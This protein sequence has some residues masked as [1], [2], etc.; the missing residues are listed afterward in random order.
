MQKNKMLESTC[1][2]FAKK[3]FCVNCECRNCENTVENKHGVAAAQKL[4][5]KKPTAF[6]SKITGEEHKKGCGCKNSCCENRYCECN[7]YNV[8]CT[9]KCR[10]VS[11]K[12]PFGTRDYGEIT[13]PGEMN[14]QAEQDNMAANVPVGQHPLPQQ[15][16]VQVPIHRPNY[17]YGSMG[18]GE[19]QRICRHASLPAN[20]ET[21]LASQPPHF[22]SK[23]YHPFT[24]RRVAYARMTQGLQGNSNSYNPFSNN[25]VAYARMM[26]QLLEDTRSYSP[27]ISNG[28]DHARMMEGLQGDSVLHDSMFNNNSSR[29]STLTNESSETNHGTQPVDVHAN[30]T[31]GTQQRT[32]FSLN[33]PNNFTAPSNNSNSNSNNNSNIG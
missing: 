5:E 22:P 17:N 9:S 25:G 32:P 7:A 24:K 1:E 28:V 26:Q 21:F 13:V 16:P 4:L 31:L 30:E 10:C 29:S 15:Q 20:L 8:K 14:T 19:N 12:N 3:E 11:C 27:F 2:C 33:L 18:N 6:D 23:P